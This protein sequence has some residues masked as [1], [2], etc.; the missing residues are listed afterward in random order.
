M[1]VRPLRRSCAT[2]SCK[3]PRQSTSP[4]SS[5]SASA[6]SPL[7]SSSRSSSR[8]SPRFS[9]SAAWST[10]GAHAPGGVPH[11][12]QRMAETPKKQKPTRGIAY[13]SAPFCHQEMQSGAFGASPQ[14]E[15]PLVKLHQGTDGLQRGSTQRPL[16]AAGTVDGNHRERPPRNPLAPDLRTWIG[17]RPKVSSACMSEVCMIRQSTLLMATWSC[18]PPRT[19]TRVWGQQS[20]KRATTTA[21]GGGGGVLAAQSTRERR[22]AEQW[23][24]RDWHTGRT[25]R[26]A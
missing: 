4:R 6:V 11:E 14:G 20:H 21:A 19:P 10:C 8:P 26:T 1:S 13:V 23:S 24:N 12:R 25:E 16:Q 3:T 2:A 17:A 7:V 22:Q 9:C 18:R 15:R 5:A